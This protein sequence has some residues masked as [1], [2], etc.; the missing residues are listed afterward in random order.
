MMPFELLMLEGFSCYVKAGCDF[1]Y[2][3]IFHNIMLCVRLAFLCYS[4]R[5]AKP[6][7]FNRTVLL[8]YGAVLA[9]SYRYTFLV[10]YMYITMLCVA[11]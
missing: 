3:V 9:F 4:H 5:S 8:S 1:S 7:F 11:L 2:A 10:Y 6:P